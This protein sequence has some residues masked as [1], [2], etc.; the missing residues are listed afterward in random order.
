M[1][2][3]TIVEIAEQLGVSTATVSRALNNAPGVGEERRQQIVAL[4]SELGYFPN[5]IARR[6]QGQRTNALC[7]AVDASKR[8]SADLFFFKDFI[9]VLAERCAE[10]G[11]DLLLHPVTQ[12]AGALDDLERLLR[13]GRAD[14]LILSDARIDDERI[15]RLSERE[16][17]FVVFGRCAQ[18]PNHAWVDVDGRTGIRKATEHLLARGHQRIALLGLPRSF[19]CA[20]DRAQGYFDAM[21]AAGIEPP[22]EWIADDLY[23]ANEAREAMERMLGLPNQPTAFVATSDMIALQ[24]MFAAARHDLR[25]GRDYAITGFDDLPMVEHVTSPLTTL[26]QPLNRVCD[27][28]ID[29]LVRVLSDE[30][31]PRQVLL[32]PELIVRESS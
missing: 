23:D 4:A 17:P 22:Q 19:S 31:G 2:R 13:S 11:F 25:A 21:Q 24:A 10:H 29:M 30:P 15:R 7:Y 5:A 27:E 20:T 1:A 12:Q 16:L 26:R 32:E 3:R 18:V 14:G 8:P 28:L 9:T 6:L